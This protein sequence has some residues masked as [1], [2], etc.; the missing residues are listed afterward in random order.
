[1]NRGPLSSRRALQLDVVIAVLSIAVGVWR[2]LNF[3][4]GRRRMLDL[5]VGAYAAAQIIGGLTLIGRRRWPVAVGRANA[6]LNLISPTQASYFVA[7][8]LGAY[9][10]KRSRAIVTFVL[11]VGGWVLG[12]QLWHL[13]DPVT[14]L[15]V[16]GLAGS[17]GLYVGARR[18]LQHAL[19]ERAERAEREQH[20]LA[21]QAVVD[22][23]IRIAGEMHDAVTHQVTLMVLQAGALSATTSVDDVRRSAEDIRMRGV[24]ALG[25]L[26]DV[27]GLLRIGED[28][29]DAATPPG[30]EGR[31]VVDL[32]NEASRA[33]LHVDL[34]ETGLAAEMS[35]EVATTFGR[36]AQEALTNAMKHAPGSRVDITVDHDVDATSISV[37]NSPPIRESSA[38]LRASG[39]GRGLEQLE[40]HVSA[41][42]G[43]F[44]ASPQPD[45]GFVLLAQVP[46][47]GPPPP[48][49]ASVTTTA[50]LVRL[51]DRT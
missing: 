45:G 29:N 40:G 50:A 26:R 2:E 21:R 49:A 42:G 5:P 41:L 16:L 10:D 31:S 39:S 47:A 28:D 27:I 11:I 22:E 23:R 3:P 36:V 19:L 18:A 34:R 7:Y 35:P 30:V 9:A 51:E 44:T 13:E 1:M 37:R 15:V 32:V 6:G 38:A 46:T 20:R 48:I 17:L 24:A 43:A 8:S 12:A 33:G 25:E 14:A 4:A